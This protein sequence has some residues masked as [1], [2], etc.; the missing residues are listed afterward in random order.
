[1]CF[2]KIQS[3]CFLFEKDALELE[4]SLSLEIRNI[5]FNQDST[6][7][8]QSYTYQMIIICIFDT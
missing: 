3:L 2:I 6:D 4:G 8:F 5:Y 1:M 7:S